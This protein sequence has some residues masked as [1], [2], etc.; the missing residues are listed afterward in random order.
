MLLGGSV[1]ENS[2]GIHKTKTGNATASRSSSLRELSRQT[3]A[4]D[5][6]KVYY[7]EISQRR[8]LSPTE[9]LHLAEQI[10]SAKEAALEYEASALAPQH[11]VQ[12]LQRIITTGRRAKDEFILSN[13]RL[14][15][16]IARKY[17]GLGLPLL[18]LIQEGNHGLMRA[19]DKFDSSRGFK[20]STYAT[21]WIQ[22]FIKRAIA[23]YGRIIRLPVHV[24]D[25]LNTL[26]KLREDL[27]LDYGSAPSEKDLAELLEISM[28][29]LKQ[30]LKL[31]QQ[32]LS[33]DELCE[34]TLN[35]DHWDVDSLF[36]REDTSDLDVSF[37]LLHRELQRMLDG[38]FHP[39]EAAVIRARFGLEDQPPRTLDEIGLEFGVTR[40][41]IRQIESK[42]ISKLR[43]PS[44]SEMLKHYLEG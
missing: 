2:D 18:D 14:V 3:E 30:L 16:H 25:K 21:P 27:L 22:Q 15:V 4:L 38:H 37:N 23:D 1:R 36:P 12:E 44:K 33:L 40:E 11:R 31:T 9:E 6:L 43:H 24:V 13:L 7:R 5:I 26:E 17:V 8:V 35:N 28:H 10:R 34:P 39:R 32:P 19:V 41:R 42:A 20:F 29:D